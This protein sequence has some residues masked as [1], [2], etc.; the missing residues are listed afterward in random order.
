MKKLDESLRFHVYANEFHGGKFLCSCDTLM[1][2]VKIKEFCS[3]S[4]SCGGNNIIDSTGVLQDDDLVDAIL[5]TEYAAKGD[6]Y[7]KE[8]YKNI[9]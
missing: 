3:N 7:Y 8:K 2:A 9:Q 6:A 5:T 1:S 4:C